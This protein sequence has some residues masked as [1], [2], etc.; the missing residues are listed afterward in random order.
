M[1]TL[2]EP[3]MVLNKMWNAIRIVPAVRALTLL[4]A[5]KASVVDG[6][7]YTIYSWDDWVALETG[8]GDK[9]ITTSSSN[10]KI[11]KVIVLSKFDK[12]P[13]KGMK[14]TK[15]NI[16]IRDD[17][18]CQYTGKKVTTKDGDIDHVKPKSKGGKTSWNNSVLCSKTVNRKKADRTPEEAGL[19]LLRLPSKPSPQVIYLDPRMIV[20]PYWEKFISKKK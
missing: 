5:D 14:L 17:F 16:F 15:R 6:E 12:L 7:D 11:P 20:D 18:T 13:K 3:V 2:D 1:N 4:F 8:E 19:R 9:Y 10:I